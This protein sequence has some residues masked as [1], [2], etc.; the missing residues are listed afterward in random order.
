MTFV[1][2]VNCPSLLTPSCGWWLR[3]SHS[4]VSGV[5]ADQLWIGNK[6]DCKNSPLTFSLLTGW[7]I[8]LL[9][10]LCEADVVCS[11]GSCVSVRAS[12]VRLLNKCSQ[13]YFLT[14]CG[15]ISHLSNEDHSAFSLVCWMQCLCSLETQREREIVSFNLGQFFCFL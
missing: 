15:C 1:C 8:V 5:A 9:L 13:H 12:C 4:S 6:D 3:S 7:R 11:F 2:T 14:Q 10:V